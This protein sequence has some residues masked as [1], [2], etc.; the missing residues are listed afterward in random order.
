MVG[1]LTDY[2]SPLHCSTWESCQ[3]PQE[4]MYRA[5]QTTSHAW[6]GEY[7]TVSGYALAVPFISHL[8]S[9]VYYIAPCSDCGFL[10]VHNRWWS[11][12]M[13]SV[14]TVFVYSAISYSS[15]FY[16]LLIVWHHHSL[17]S[18]AHAQDVWWLNGVHVYCLYTSPS[19]SPAQWPPTHLYITCIP[20]V[21][22]V[23][24][25]HTHTFT[26]SLIVSL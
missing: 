20:I 25:S 5:M 3:S 1:W 19:W 8:I 21:R 23:N 17:Y 16:I 11:C 14:C 10:L 15:T 7:I 6:L 12:G 13:Y 4:Y 22:N 26:P 2:L 24:M 18:H 9:S